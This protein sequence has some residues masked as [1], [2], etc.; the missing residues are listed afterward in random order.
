MLVRT[1]RMG[2]DEGGFPAG[3]MRYAVRARRPRPRHTVGCGGGPG[4]HGPR[5]AGQRFGHRGRSVRGGGGRRP[6]AGWRDPVGHDRPYRTGDRRP[7]LRAPALPRGQPVEPAPRGGGQAG[8]HQLAGLRSGRSRHGGSSRRQRPRN[9][10][11]PDGEF[12]LEATETLGGTW[13]AV[14]TGTNSVSLPLGP[15]PVRY[16]RLA[17]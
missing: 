2:N 16:Y 11:G 9:H 15:E 12:L 1:G 3:S 17:R 13:T 5:A 10:R 14:A 8:R 6:A 4:A 7:R